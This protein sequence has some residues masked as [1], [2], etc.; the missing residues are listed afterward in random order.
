MRNANMRVKGRQT[1]WLR[2]RFILTFHYGIRKLFATSHSIKENWS[3]VSL[4]SIIH[5]EFARDVDVAV[6]HA[7]SNNKLTYLEMNFDL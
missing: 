2:C 6:A 3:Y 7:L 5:D 1:N 4:F